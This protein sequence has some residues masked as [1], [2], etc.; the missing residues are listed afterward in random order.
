MP[1]TSFI[2]MIALCT[3]IQFADLHRSSR[4]LG[5]EPSSAVLRASTGLDLR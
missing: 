2:A 3:T 5:G 1:S 4:V